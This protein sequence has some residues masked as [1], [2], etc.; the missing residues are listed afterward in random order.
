MVRR[1]YCIGEG[2]EGDAGVGCD[3][4]ADF[5]EAELCGF[6]VVLGAECGD[7]L[8]TDVADLG[9]VEDAFEAVADFDLALAVLDGEEHEDAAVGLLLADFPLGK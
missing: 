9:I 5:V 7:H 8:A 2:D 6:V 1:R 3:D 4:A